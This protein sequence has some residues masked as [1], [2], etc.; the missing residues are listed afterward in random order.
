MAT[1]P[2]IV[3]FKAT[4]VRHKNHQTI[5]KTGTSQVNRTPALL[6]TRCSRQQI[7]NPLLLIIK[8]WSMAKADIADAKC[9]AGQRKADASLP[10]VAYQNACYACSLS[11]RGMGI[12]RPSMKIRLV[13]LCRLGGPSQEPEMMGASAWLGAY[14]KTICRAWGKTGS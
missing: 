14:A 4:A 6:G 8:L 3:R 10:T 2:V 5:E 13:N 7:S 12:A 11:T 1:F 9:P